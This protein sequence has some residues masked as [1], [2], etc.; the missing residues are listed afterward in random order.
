MAQLTP[1]PDDLAEKHPSVT[2][3]ERQWRIAFDVVPG[4]ADRILDGIAGGSTL[5]R[6][7]NPKRRLAMC[8]NDH[9]L[10]YINDCIDKQLG[11]GAPA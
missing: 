4:L 10:Y 8:G 6:N 1:L 7:A 3:D 9:R 5:W 2:W 11:L